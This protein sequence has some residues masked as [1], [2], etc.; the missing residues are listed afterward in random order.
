VNEP[1]PQPGQ[2]DF[3]F[4]KHKLPIDRMIKPNSQREMPLVFQK[5]KVFS[6]G[7]A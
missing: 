1:A 3:V 7:A 6:V 2:S 5:H 4:L